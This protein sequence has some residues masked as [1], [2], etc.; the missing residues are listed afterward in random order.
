MLFCIFALLGFNDLV[1]ESDS[2][3]RVILGEGQYLKPDDLEDVGLF[4]NLLRCS[5][6]GGQ[7]IFR[8]AVFA[9][10]LE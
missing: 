10:L 1:T 9:E 8:I 3:I 5:I 6:Q 4:W 7:Q 2:I